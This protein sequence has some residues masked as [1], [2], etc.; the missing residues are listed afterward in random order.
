MPAWLLNDSAPLDLGMQ[1]DPAAVE[2]AW[3][4]ADSIHSLPPRFARWLIAGVTKDAAGSPLGF[5]EV[6]LFKAGGAPYGQRM[7]G[8]YQYGTRAL[9]F[10]ATNS[11][12][13]GNYSFTVWD[14]DDYFAVAFLPGSPEVMGV[15]VDTLQGV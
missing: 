1:F 15:T 7:Y 8:T 12:V 3:D 13:N 2:N 9:D 6:R 10:G 11:D 5:C 14:Q 4:L